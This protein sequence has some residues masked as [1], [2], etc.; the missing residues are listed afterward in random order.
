MVNFEQEYDV[1]VATEIGDFSIGGVSQWID[2][3]IR[4][5]VPYLR[6]RPV[7]V[8]EVAPTRGWI[9]YVKQFALITN[10]PGEKH[11]IEWKYPISTFDVYFSLPTTEYTDEIIKRARKVH[12][13]SCPHS[14][15]FRK[16]TEEA[17]NSY[18]RIDSL[19][20]HSSEKESIKTHRK[21]LHTRRQREIFDQDKVIDFYEGLIEAAEETIW[22]GVNEMDKIDHHIPNFYKFE[23]NL[24]AIN[25]DIVGFAARVE[26]RKNFHYLE[27]VESRALTNPDGLEWW[28]TNYKNEISFNNVSVEPYTREKVE[29]FY[30]SSEWGIFHG[31]Y[32]NEPFGYSIFQS[33]DYGKIPIISK[34]WCKDMEY[35]FRANTVKQF[36]TQVAKIKKLSIEERNTYLQHLRKYLLKFSSESNWRDNLLS[37]YNKSEDGVWLP[38]D[39]QPSNG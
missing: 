39:L 9:E 24:E 20:V 12:L 34:D 13:L 3:W 27:N 17:I 35:P 22:I 5:V 33:I 31:A 14:K 38:G 23:N 36:E 8:I 29:K 37:I 16:S 25:N 28:E 2:S 10:V 26:A 18:H 21:Y 15:L 4:Y 1:Y 19:V 7:L 30:E 11:E 32:V 6:V